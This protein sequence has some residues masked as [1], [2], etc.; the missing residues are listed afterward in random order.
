MEVRTRGL[1]EM[2]GLIFDFEVFCFWILILG[3]HS[4]DMQMM[5]YM[6]QYALRIILMFVAGKQVIIMLNKNIEVDVKDKH[7]ENG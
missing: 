3:I 1:S 6:L 7:L 5:V 4:K 2:T